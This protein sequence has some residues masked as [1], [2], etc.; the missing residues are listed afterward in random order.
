MSNADVRLKMPSGAFT[1]FALRILEVKRLLSL[2]TPEDADYRIKKDNVERDDALLR[3]A[4]VLLC[5]HLEGYFE[6]LVSDLISAYDH[7]ASHVALLPDELRAQQVTGGSS[8]WEVKDPRKRWQTVQAWSI[9]PLIQSD[10]EKPIGCMEAS[11]HIDGFSNPGSNEIETLFRTVGISDIWASFR[12]VEPDQLI[13]QS[14]NAIVH[15]RNQIAHGN[16][17][18]TIT[19]SDANL[20]VQRAERIAEV[21]EQLIF[22][23]INHRL[24]FQDCWSA[25]EQSLA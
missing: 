22:A 11:L 14:V 2:C 8:K 20:Y 12:V 9:H 25:L 19:L 21:F 5:S 17:D 6:D 10:A 24:T 1:K 18:A 15:R 7:L 4:H 16:A 3:G 23:E 13:F